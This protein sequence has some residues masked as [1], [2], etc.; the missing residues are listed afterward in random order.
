MTLHAA[1]HFHRGRLR[2]GFRRIHRPSKARNISSYQRLPP[3][4]QGDRP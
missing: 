3:A 2:E 4:R 1:V